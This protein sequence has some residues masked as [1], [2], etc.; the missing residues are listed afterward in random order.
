MAYLHCHTKGCHWSQD[1]FWH[2]KYNPL[3]KLWSD[4]RWLWKPR[5]MKFDR[6]AYGRLHIFSWH[7]LVLEIAKEAHNVCQMK[8][9]TWE[10]WKRAK[11]TAVCP[12]CG[13]R[14]WDI[15]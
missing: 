4:I 10:S 11:D 5:M 12:K 15:D 3:T 13:Q 2:R 8:W 7:A 6:E 14:N 1:D 9:W